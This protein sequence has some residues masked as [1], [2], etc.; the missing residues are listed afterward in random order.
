MSLM[1][2]TTN[3]KYIPYIGFCLC[4]FLLTDCSGSQTQPCSLQPLKEAISVLFSFT[5]RVLDDTQFQTDIHHW[6]D[7]LVHMHKHCTT[8]LSPCSMGQGILLFCFLTWF[9]STLQVAVLLHIGGSAEHLYLLC[10]LLCCPA[11]VGKWA[12]HFL[13]VS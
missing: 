8:F 5:R 3:M 6:L 11:G 13:Q 7:R 1:H 10:H 12:A 4:L 2:N 9:W